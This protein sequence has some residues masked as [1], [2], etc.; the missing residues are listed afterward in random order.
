MKIDLHYGAYP[1]QGAINLYSCWCIG[2]GLAF[3]FLIHPLQ[4]AK[5]AGF[6][7]RQGN[8]DDCTCARSRASST[9]F[10]V[11]SCA[12]DHSLLELL[13][14]TFTTASKTSEVRTVSMSC[15]APHA[16]PILAR[17]PVLIGHGDKVGRAQASRVRSRVASQFA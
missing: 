15:T 12:S 4:G 17:R 6:S 16:L 2:L 7:F 1:G 5:Q 11:Y 10:I 14:R 8:W 3:C 9:L 13:S